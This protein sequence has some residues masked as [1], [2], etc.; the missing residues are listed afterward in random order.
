MTASLHVSTL[1]VTV[2]Q[3]FYAIYADLLTASFN[4]LKRIELD[5]NGTMTKRLPLRRLR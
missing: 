5:H 3:Q 4:I 2:T 1:I